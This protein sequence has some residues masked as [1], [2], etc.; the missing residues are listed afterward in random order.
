M[1]S[2]L[3]AIPRM[4]KGDVLLA[5]SICFQSA[6]TFSQFQAQQIGQRPLT[7]T[8][9]A[10]T[11]CFAIAACAPN[12][13]LRALR[14][15]RSFIILAV[16]A[17]YAAGIMEAALSGNNALAATACSC[18]A[19]ACVSLCIIGE[20]AEL[21]KRKAAP[22]VTICCLGFILAAV[23]T[24]IVSLLP[25][26]F[27]QSANTLYLALFLG[28]FLASRKLSADDLP[29]D[30]PPDRTA[31]SPAFLSGVD[32]E[33]L[34]PAIRLGAALSVVGVAHDNARIGYYSLMDANGIPI[35]G[36]VWEG[37]YTLTTVLGVA[38]IGMAAARSKD[39]SWLAPCYRVVVFACI[40][41]QLL[42]LAPIDP[43]LH[44]ALWLPIHMAVFRCAM[45]FSWAIVLC[46]PR[47]GAQ[48]RVRVFCL[49]QSLLFVG[50]CAGH[51]IWRFANATS[52]ASTF[53]FPLML[54]STLLLL[55]SYLTLFT[56]SDLKKLTASRQRIPSGQFMQRCT[57][58]AEK[59]GL[60][61]RE[62]EVMILFAKG[63]NLDYIRT[64]L[65]VSKSTV[66]MHR[67]HIYRKLDIHSQQ[68]LI[69]LIEK[70]Q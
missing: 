40:A 26:Q 27:A 35:S 16:A 36:T 4:G 34:R 47:Q 15:S 29:S 70:P 50:S 17:F 58:L 42:P 3:A 10:S 19:S 51:G 68:E 24:L 44:A 54:T 25:E 61:N 64:A 31:P 22:S 49:T 62:T 5:A 1:P 20:F 28:S 56:E 13:I 65:C 59:H 7:A 69:N 48:G 32:R 63:R 67:Q 57:S 53:Y 33:R 21:A 46:M 41:A 38:A 6:L 8:M 14:R 23:L 66:S 55:L 52:E 39:D 43:A 12:R 60:S 2:F 37:L 30:E 11:L 45:C 18:A 9:L